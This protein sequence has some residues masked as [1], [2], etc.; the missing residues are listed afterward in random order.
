MDEFKKSKVMWHLVK[1]SVVFSGGKE[2]IK[3]I[4]QKNGF[5]S[6]F[7][8][9]YRIMVDPTNKWAIDFPDDA[10]SAESERCRHM[11]DNRTPAVYA[12]DLAAN[13]FMETCLIDVLKNK[14]G[15]KIRLNGSDSNRKI[16]SS[17]VQNSSDVLIANENDDFWCPMEISMCYTSKMKNT[18]TFHFRD[19]KLKHIK[20]DNGIVL[21]IEFGSRTFFLFSPHLDTTKYDVER[22]ERSSELG[23]KVA[24]RIHILNNEDIVDISN[25]SSCLKSCIERV[26]SSINNKNDN[27]A[28]EIDMLSHD[29]DGSEMVDSLVEFA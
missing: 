26:K 23:M 28:E 21:H 13:W 14:F 20:D 8:S 2:Q 11:R 18:N 22:I 9:A 10:K 7:P 24:T 27:K 29:D 16:L 15:F 4:A 3:E 5:A 25:L 12:I 1:E 17:N 6:S 19:N